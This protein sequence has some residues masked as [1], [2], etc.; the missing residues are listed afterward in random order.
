MCS[1]PCSSLSS[2]VTSVALAAMI[3][4]LCNRLNLSSTPTCALAPK[5][6]WCPSSFCAFPDRAYH[7]FLAELGAWISVASTTVPWRNDRPRSP[8]Q[9]S[10][11]PKYHGSQ[12][13]LSSDRRKLKMVVS[14]GYVQDQPGKLAQDSG[15][16]SVSSIAG[17][18][19]RTSSASD[20][21]AE[22]PSPKKPTDRLMSIFFTQ[23]WDMIS[24]SAMIPSFYE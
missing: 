8:R 9:P 15:F 21:R 4:T 13:M 20:A 2:C 22:L 12:L 7:P 24:F 5:Q 3:S 14:L 18:C 17:G 19:S 6:Y 16:H 10:T 23:G 11:N 1:E